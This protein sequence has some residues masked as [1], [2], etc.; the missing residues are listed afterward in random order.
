MKVT[1]IGSYKR[2]LFDRINNAG[3]KEGERRSKDVIASEDD[4]NKEY[5]E[6]LELFKEACK[7]IGIALAAEKHRL[8]LAHL[9]D[10]IAAERPTLE[11][12][13]TYPE[14]FTINKKKGA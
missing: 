5:E 13:R 12:F 14:L 11:G 7:T 9:N 10:D 6:R 8:I 1:V 3:M 2:D 4:L